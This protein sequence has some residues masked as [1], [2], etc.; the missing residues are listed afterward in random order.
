MISWNHLGRLSGKSLLVQV[1][2]CWLV[3]VGVCSGALA[4]ESKPAK[5]ILILFSYQSVT[6]GFLE[7]DEGIRSVLQGTPR[8]PMEFYI[9]FLDLARFP[10]KVYLQNIVNFLQEKYSGKK[11]DLLIPVAPLAFPFLLDHGNTI[12]PEVPTVFC[13]ALKHEVLELKRPEKLHRG[14]RLRRCGRYFGAALKMQP[15]TRRLA[16]IGGTSE[17]DRAFQPFTRAGTY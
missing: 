3:I 1:I 7:W 17:S 6:P 16:I 13:A 2:S 4:A 9:E 10:D 14:G 5:G 8:E 12:F 15:N 11:L